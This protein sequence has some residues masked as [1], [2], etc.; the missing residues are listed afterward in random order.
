MTPNQI[1][2]QRDRIYRRSRSQ[3]IQTMGD[4]ARFIDAVGFCL[5]FASAQGIELPS[6]FE[7]VKGRRDAHIDDWDDDSDRVW[8]WKNDLPAARRAYY[9][10]ALAGRPG[11]VSLKM[12]PYLYAVTAPENL[13]DEYARGRISLDAKR[14]YDALRVLGPTPTMALRAAVGL[15]RAGDGARYHRALDQLQ[16]A[17]VILPVGATVERGA[18]SSQIFELLARWFP[19]QVA[20]AQQIDV[21]TAR[22]VLVKRY[23]ETVVAAKPPMIGRVLG[24]PREQLSAMLD[25]LI[26]RRVLTKKEDWVVTYARAE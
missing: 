15:D 2:Q 18:W 25:D 5:L 21:D 4:A 17:M 3:R 7:A 14:V 8:G 10:K 11:F 9:G 12:L 26:A 22:R 13:D 16:R 23:V 24:W 1:E 6:L 19:R 20:R